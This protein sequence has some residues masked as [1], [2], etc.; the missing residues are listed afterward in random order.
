LSFKI[1]EGT[2]LQAHL[3]QWVVIA[4]FA[5]WIT[6]ILAGIALGTRQAIS[7]RKACAPDRDEKR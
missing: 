5:F 2:L 1:Y 4:P 6:F 7:A 3:R